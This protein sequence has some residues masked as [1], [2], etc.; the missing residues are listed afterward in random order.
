[1]NE[2]RAA[3]GLGDR[4]A[5]VRTV[6]GL[7]TLAPT[8][9]EGLVVG[10]ARRDR[11]DGV[12]RFIE[13]WLD[14]LFASCGVRLAIE[15]RE[16]LS[17]HRP[18]VFLFNHCN[19]FDILVAAKVVGRRFTSVGK[20]E[21]ADNPLSAALGALVDAVFIDRSDQ[22]SAVAALKPVEEAV[23][24]KKLSLIISP[25]GT[26]SPTGEI[27]P[28]KKGPFRIAMATKVPVVPIVI[29]NAMDLGGRGAMAMHPA[30][31]D[32]RVLPPI[33]TAR[34]KLADLDR[35]IA[36]VR[37]QFIDTLENW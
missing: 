7:A 37:Q 17:S 20:K 6:V 8:A 36:G 30:T 25:E 12:D 34:W 26:R 32:V 2:A 35:K 11:R 10:L 21:A 4:L 16:H 18:A 24:D 33:P 28:F 29:R 3:S 15:G 1:M 14:S 19:N 22:A 5:P 23:R 9:V 27:L 31:V 13:R